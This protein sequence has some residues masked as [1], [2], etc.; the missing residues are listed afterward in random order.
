MALKMFPCGVSRMLPRGRVNSGVMRL[1]HAKGIQSMG[2]KIPLLSVTKALNAQAHPFPVQVAVQTYEFILGVLFYAMVSD[3]ASGEYVRLPNG[4]NQMEAKLLEEGLSKKEWDR[5]W[6]IIQKYMP[7]FENTVFQN[8]LMLMRSHWDWYIRQIGGFVR[9]SRNH[10]HSPPLDNKQQK[11]LDNVDRK[12]LKEQLQI[13]EMACGITFN[14][15]ATVM[16]SIREMSCVRNLGMHNRW[17]VDNF[18][19]S[20]TSTSGWELNDIRLLEISELRG[21]ASSLNKIIDE[22]SFPIAIKY[23]SAPDY[24]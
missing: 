6:N 23:V 11:L 22:T 20:K 14:I 17:E 16:E 8:V 7:V 9:F 1:P 15:P 3:M 5:G 21:W 24:P 2:I 13:L 19:L 10:V 18:Y 12:E 4:L